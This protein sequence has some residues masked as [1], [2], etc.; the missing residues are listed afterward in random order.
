VTGIAD[1]TTMSL[2][3]LCIN[4]V[5]TLAMD[6]VQK[7]ES[8]HPGAP[9]A[10]APLAYVLFT[11]HMRHNPT[12]PTWPNRD[13]FVL[14]NGHASM[15]LYASLFMSGYDVTLDDLKEFRQWGSRT[16][17]HPEHGMTP[18]VETTTG[19]L[20]QGLANAVGMAAAE[21]HLAGVFNREGHTIVGHHTYF[22]AGDGCMMEGISHEAASF[23][24]HFGL[25]KLIGFY[26]D[27]H[28]SIDGSTDLTYSDDAAKR[29]EA[30]GWHVLRVADGNDLDALDR[31]IVEAQAET[32]R[33]TLVIVRTHI[34]FGSPNKQDTAKAHGE[35]LGAKEIE[36]TKQN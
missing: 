10:L 35:A 28:I 15:L 14:S 33:P 25:G 11:R 13:R 22:I 7:A 4:T 27:N 34:G 31:A 26:D 12:D 36:L 2:D 30:Y 8:G 19:P 20:G 21:A 1:A 3:A 9:M 32:K 24:G 6:A 18:G 5:R 29:F 16:P 23:A 17:G